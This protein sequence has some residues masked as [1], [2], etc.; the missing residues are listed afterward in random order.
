MSEPQAWFGFGV[1][2]CITIAFI[3]LC[4]TVYECNKLG[5]EDSDDS[6]GSEKPEWEYR[7]ECG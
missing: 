5:S 4:I 2:V 7:T 3:A 1:A 6:D